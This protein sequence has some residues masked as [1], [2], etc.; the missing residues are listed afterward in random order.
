MDFSFS[1]TQNDAAALAAMVFKNECT[2]DRLK[3]ALGALD[4]GKAAAMV[5]GSD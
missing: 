2:P 3:A 4:G 5:T 1:E